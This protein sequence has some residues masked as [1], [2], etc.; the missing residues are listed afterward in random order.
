[1]R[2]RKLLSAVLALALALAL[3]VPA[4]AAAPGGSDLLTRGEFVAALFDRMGATGK[5][6]QSAFED[7]P[8]DGTLAR[9]VA[10]AAANGIVNG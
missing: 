4:F 8:A 2:S 7:V 10:W 3:A 6:G 1:M 9:A 5:A